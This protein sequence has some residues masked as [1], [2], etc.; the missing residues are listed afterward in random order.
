[1][2][3]DETYW[4][5]RYQND[6]T[7]WDIGTVSTPLKEY[8]DQLTIKNIAILIPGC[9]NS[10]E[11]EYLL[12]QG[13]SNVTLVDISAVLCKKLEERLA[14]YLHKELK[15]ICGDFFEH[16]GQYDL[17][18]EQTFF[19]ALDPSL[20][21]SYADTIYHLL[22]TGGK[23]VGVLFNRQ[24]E[25]GPPFGGSSN[26]YLSLFQDQFTIEL[27]EECYNSITPRKDAELFVKLIKSTH[28]FNSFSKE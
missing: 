14:P 23:L 11:A 16:Q 19:C 6:E 27:M 9:G 4:S 28:S 1:M 13:F 17:I 2:A 12:Q 24:F 22:K 5:G 10:H 26:E 21:K 15:I 8:F 25:G 3:L 18:I 7:G 20:R